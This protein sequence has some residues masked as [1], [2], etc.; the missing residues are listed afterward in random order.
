MPAEH[1]LIS[2]VTPVWNPPVS[3]LREAIASVVRQAVTDWELVLVDDQ[4]TD[5]QVRAVL[6]EAAAGDERIRVV[7]RSTNGGIVAAS[8][9]GIAHA[10]GEFVALLDHDDVLA[11]DA[12]A[13]IEPHL[14]EPDL[15]YLYTD[16]CK[17]D[18]DAHLYDPFLKPIWSPERLRGQMYTGHLS[19]L[20]TSLVRAVGG[21]REGFDGSQD[22]D[23]ALRV[24][25]QARRIVHVPQVL[26]YWRAV[27]GS[28][29]L[30]PEAKP[31]SWEA[32]RRAV[33][34]HLERV[35]IHAEAELGPVPGTY[36]VRRR[37]DPATTVSVVI[38]TRGSGGLVWGERR[39]FVVEAVRSV[40]RTCH[41][42]GLE[43]VVV[44]DEPTPQAV[45][46]ELTALAGDR[47]TLVRF[48][49][50]FNF[51]AKCNVGVIEARGDVVVLLNDDVQ[52]IDDES[53]EQ[54]VAL[55]LEPG[56]GASG[57]RL[58]FEDGRLQHGS[59]V[60]DGGDWYHVRLW[61]SADDEGPFRS[62]LVGREASGLTAA[63]LAVRRDLYL[64][65]GGM[66]ES[67]PGNF[68]DVD[69]SY[70]VRRAGQRLVWTPIVTA[71]HFE[72]RTRE[73]KVA[74]WEIAFVQS[75]WGVPDSEPYMR[76]RT[77]I[78]DRE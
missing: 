45:L 3:A 19:V 37:L 72:S 71:Y 70:K 52:L 40:L 42:P 39:C 38:P 63:F 27:S 30:D 5:L 35:G 61:A 17:I 58:L 67:L 14:R 6:R 36:R 49:E 20:R 21:F 31:Y 16:E 77:R 28:T 22:H 78:T 26:Y 34:E 53:I 4:S 11:D 47:L 43:I 12:F 32:G 74:R 9:D 2:V 10:R 29:A 62:L 23:L 66:C 24:T 13:A 73:P 57:A 8:N 1:P 64:E 44:Y 50:K 60:Y 46:D 41:L 76:Q 56:V 68:N 54:L 65:L 15:D 25:E 55:A 51:S 7:E 69:F 48:T 59:H 33:A 75:R 18:E